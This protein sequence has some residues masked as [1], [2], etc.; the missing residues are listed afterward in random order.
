MDSDSGGKAR[1]KPGSAWV[2]VCGGGGLGGVF[3][4][5]TAGTLVPGGY[6][7]TEMLLR[8]SWDSHSGGHAWKGQE[9][10]PWASACRALPVPP[11]LHPPPSWALWEAGM[12]VLDE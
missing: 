12:F 1:R 7:F 6:L 8:A 11:L 3:S 2:C 10:M 4:G 5:G 9:K